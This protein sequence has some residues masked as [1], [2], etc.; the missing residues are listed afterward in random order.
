MN[1]RVCHTTGSPMVIFQTYVQKGCP[2]VAL[3]HK[4][5]QTWP[6]VMLQGSC[7]TLPSRYVTVTLLRPARPPPS[8]MC[9]LNINNKIIPADL[10]CC[11]SYF[12]TQLKL[13]IQNTAV[14]FSI[15][16]FVTNYLH[17]IYNP[18]I[19]N[20]ILRLKTINTNH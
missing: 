11:Q 20:T 9:F 19:F 10:R 17:H 8:E 12:K 18:H 7:A 13:F 2:W 6:P 3:Y 4:T 15:N 5:V 1:V 16:I 14:Y